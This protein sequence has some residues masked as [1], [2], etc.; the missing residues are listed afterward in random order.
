MVKEKRQEYDVEQDG[1]YNDNVVI[2]IVYPSGT[3][4]IEKRE[5]IAACLPDL[6]SAL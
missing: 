6:V 5:S 2:V 4:V 3:R 1:V